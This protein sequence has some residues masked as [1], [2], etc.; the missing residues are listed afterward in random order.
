MAAGA[1]VGSIVPVPILGT[2]VGAVVGLGVGVASAWMLN[3]KTGRAVKQFARDSVKA[4]YD[5]AVEMGK[6]LWSSGKKFFGN[7]K[8]IWGS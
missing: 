7:M 5:G 8:S 1:F 4:V 3:T 2:A 6:G